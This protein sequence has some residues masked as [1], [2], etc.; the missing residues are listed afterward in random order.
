MPARSAQ[1]HPRVGKKGAVAI[2]D[3]LALQ[4]MALWQET[5][6]TAPFSSTLSVACL[7]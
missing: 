6:A 7:P 1:T 5:P 4:N 3:A 2:R